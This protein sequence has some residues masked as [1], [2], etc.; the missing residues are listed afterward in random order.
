MR[1]FLKNSSPKEII[2]FTDSWDVILLDN[3]EDIKKIYFN[4]Y[5]LSFFGRRKFLLCW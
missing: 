1:D 3:L 5:T 4:E 2:C